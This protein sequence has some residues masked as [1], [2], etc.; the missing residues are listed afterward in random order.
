[1]TNFKKVID[2]YL[3]DKKR[4]LSLFKFFCET[5]Y[6]VTSSVDVESISAAVTPSTFYN[7]NFQQVSTASSVAASFWS[8][9]APQATKP[10][11]AIAKHKLNFSL[12]FFELKIIYNTNILLLVNQITC[13]PLKMKNTC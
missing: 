10:I 8:S 9:G 11:K 13:L 12:Y 5:D 3:I 7:A 6:S 2:Y 4:G 1:M